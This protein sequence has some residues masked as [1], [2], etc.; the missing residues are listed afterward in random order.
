MLNMLKTRR[1]DKLILPDT[2]WIGYDH[3]LSG[4]SQFT[5]PRRAFMYNVAFDG[6]S[7]KSPFSK[8]LQTFL[9]DSSLPFAKVLPQEVIEK[10]FRKYDGLFGGTFYNAA[11]V[12]WAFLLQTFPMA[13]RVPVRRQWDALPRFVLASA[14]IR[15]TKTRTT[16]AKPVQNFRWTHCTNSSL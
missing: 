7:G 1:F 11:F 6:R 2:L 10:V 8:I 9:D 13:S 15:P 16:I 4:L 5:M 12:L 14:K 3:A